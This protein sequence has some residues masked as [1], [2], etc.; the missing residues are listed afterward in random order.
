MG[1]Y[2][3]IMLTPTAFGVVPEVKN[4]LRFIDWLVKS[5]D[6]RSPEVGP[7]F[8]VETWL[9]SLEEEETE[10]EEFLAIDNTLEMYL[11]NHK[12]WNISLEGPHYK[13]KPI[14]GSISYNFRIG[15]TG[16]GT[17][18]NPLR[19][20]DISNVNPQ[21]FLKYEED[22]DYWPDRDFSIVL[23]SFVKVDDDLQVEGYRDIIWEKLVS[24]GVI[25]QIQ[26]VLGVSLEPWPHI[27]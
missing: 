4:I 22:K 10:E 24:S 1:M 17:E 25:S 11:L 12:N 27:F 19:N 15:E 16:E 3:A 8:V 2:Y 21:S 20:I 7:P 26:E 6:I 18:S 5:G 23:S 9:E 14:L 13:D